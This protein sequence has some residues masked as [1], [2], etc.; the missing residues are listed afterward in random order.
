[1]K[2]RV[3]LIL[4]GLTIA[5]IVG[6]GCAP[7]TDGTAEPPAAT[8]PLAPPTVA[9]NLPPTPAPT[10]EPSSNISPLTAPTLVTLPAPIS[11]DQSSPAPPFPTDPPADRAVNDLAQRLQV[12]PDAITVVSVAT[13][14][15][16]A[17]NLGCYPDGKAPQVDIPAFVMGEEI[18]LRQGDQEYIY[19]A[20]GSLV[21]YCGQ[22]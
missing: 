6:T 5:M 20:R 1:M 16:P 15:M 14:D 2:L 8:S 13:T 17:Q 11:K 10:Q 12:P 9:P 3:L 19:R 18:V 7:P 21:V 4:T 22:R